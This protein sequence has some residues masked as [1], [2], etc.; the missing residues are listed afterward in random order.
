MCF[1]LPTQVADFGLARSLSSNGGVEPD[2]LGQDVLTDYIATRWY[3]APEILVASTKYGIEVDLWSLGCIFAEMISA[4]PCFS[5]T[6]TLNQLE[7]IMETLGMPSESDLESLAS[8]YASSMVQNC[9]VDV[10]GSRSNFHAP[11]GEAPGN[12]R[13]AASPAEAPAPVAPAPA[14]AANGGEKSTSAPGP[15][16]TDEV[17]GRW[18]ERFA[19]LVE[20]SAQEDVIDLLHQMMRFNKHNRINA[21]QGLEHPYCRQFREPESETEARFRVDIPISDNLKKATK[22]YRDACYANGEEESLDKK[23]EQLRNKQQAA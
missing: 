22:E 10:S 20:E 15:L 12:E 11:S 21:Q 5:G 4:K 13:L 8:H 19:S 14:P 6:S 17:R 23:V 18:R 16:S 9:T 2:N 7:K 3:R 1:L